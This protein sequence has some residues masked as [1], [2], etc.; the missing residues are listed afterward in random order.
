MKELEYYK[1][2]QKKLEA[3][4][5][6]KKANLIIKEALYIISLGTND[7]LENYYLLPTRRS[8]YTVQQFQD[9]LLGISTKFVKELYQLG[10][11]KISMTGLPPMGCLPLERTANKLRGNGD[12][13]VDSY[14]NVALSFNN[15][16]SALINNLNTELPG[17]RIVFADVF[18][19]FHHII[20]NYSSYGMFFSLLT[21]F[22][23]RFH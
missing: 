12:K 17:V 18:Y 9:Y 2:Y 14:N 10:A 23:F 7:F 8:Q 22:F 5:G 1:E 11:R 3:Y 21:R 4:A 20:R 16:L 6:E 19:I 13:C 15:K